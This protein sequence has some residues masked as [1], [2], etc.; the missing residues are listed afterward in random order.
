MDNSRRTLR[1]GVV[2]MRTDRGIDENIARA[3]AMVVEAAASGAKLVVLPEFFAC[4]YSYS[5]DA[6]ALAEPLSGRSAEVLQT[7]AREH[8]IWL[9]G[10]VYERGDTACFDTFILAGPDGE[11]YTHRKRLPSSFESFFFEPGTDPVVVSTPLGRIALV[12]CYES[13]LPEVLTEVVDERAELVLIGYS[14]PGTSP[15]LTRLLGG[16]P[17][18]M[19]RR[20][21]ARWARTTG[22]PTAV[23]CVTGTWTSKVPYVPLLRF[24]LPFHGQ[25][26]VYDAAGKTLT[27]MDSTEGVVVT[28]VELG[29][30]SPSLAVPSTEFVE[31]IPWLVGKLL[32]L[33]AVIGAPSYRRWQ[34]EQSRLRADPGP[35][36]LI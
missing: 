26:A 8:E 14:S 34:R 7:L 1:V 19:L 24:S 20:L 16:P 13:M 9:G 31:P 6:R 36:H 21:G 15:W 10:C 32:K 11:Q 23:A 5:L 30:P 25:S 28:D 33:P 35:K 12:I 2:Q 3:R 22:A 4:G 29:A 18:D 17:L 27:S